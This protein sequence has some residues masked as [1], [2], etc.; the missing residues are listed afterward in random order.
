MYQTTCQDIYHFLSH[1]LDLTSQQRFPSPREISYNQTMSHPNPKTAMSLSLK[2]H[3]PSLARQRFKLILWIRQACE[4]STVL[5]S[6]CCFPMW[7]L[8][9]HLLTT[10]FP[11]PRILIGRL[12]HDRD[13]ED[14]RSKA[15][16]H[17]QGGSCPAGQ[18]NL[19]Q[20]NQQ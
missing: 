14:T 1:A 7:D 2:I 20:C 6:P 3:H 4:V 13:Q 11:Y 10:F 16:Y 19:L 15:F 5:A 8:V 9:S 12:L 17:R 18:N